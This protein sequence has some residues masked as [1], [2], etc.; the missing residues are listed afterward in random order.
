VNVTAATQ[1]ATISIL[2][3]LLLV[4]MALPDPT[5][6]KVR[7]D[8]GKL[9][10][11]E[12]TQTEFHDLRS[13]LVSAELLTAGK[14]NTFNITA[15]GR[16]KA[17]QFVGLT[18]FPPRTTWA[19]VVGKV[20]FPKAAGLS[21]ESAAKLDN[22]DKLGAFVLKQKYGLTAKAGN[23]V[24]QV[25]QA[26]A[27]KELGF[28]EERTLEGLLC[29][30]VSKLLG[31]ERFDKKKLVKQLPLFIT[32]LNSSRSEGFRCKVV[33]NWLA[34][35]SSVS[36]PI[37]PPRVEQLD[38]PTF[39]A[40]VRALAVNSPAEDRFHDNKVF[41]GAL[42]RSSQSEPSFPRLMLDEFKQQLIDANSRGLLHLSRADLVQEM[43]PQLV[44]ESETTYLNATFHFVLLEGGVQ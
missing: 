19:T 5:P 17:L 31:D 12:L 14:R 39:A 32:G 26:V 23:T 20:L 44:A 30:V 4:R 8:L 16:E 18:E 34:G 15:A 22:S 38:L 2:A 43:D 42:W 25:I 37:E 11:R 27:C 1:T 36:Q 13:E 21:V 10:G 3:E 9:L 28:P 6:L 40:T 41:I 33:Q 24:N 7:Q 29:S 35:I